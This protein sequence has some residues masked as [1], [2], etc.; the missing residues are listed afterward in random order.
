MGVPALNGYDYRHAEG[1]T[2]PN[3]V[4]WVSTGNGTNTDFEIPNLSKGTQYAVEVRAV[5]DFGESVSSGIT[6]FETNT[7]VTNAPTNLRVVS[8]TTTEINIAFNAPTDDGGAEIEDYSIEVDGTAS[9]TGSTA[10][11]ARISGLTASETV[12]IRV[13]GVNPEGTGAYSDALEATTDAEFAITTAETD[14]REGKAFDI[15]IAATGDVNLTQAK[16]SVTGAT[17]DDFVETDAQNYV[18][19][20]TADAG[21]G[22]IVVEIAEDAVS[23]GNAPVSKTFTRKALPSATITANPPTI[24]HGR[25]TELTI[26]FDEDV[27]GVTDA[28]ASV[29]V[30]S[31]SNFSV[32]S[33]REIT[34]DVT[35][36]DMSGLGTS[37]SPS[38]VTLQRLA[39]PR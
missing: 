12:S 29:D 30:G 18:L 10:T 4:G 37:R 21:A 39:T 32:V 25:T 14:I 1:T 13:A 15:D 27:D 5:S 34:V 6:T 31:L 9:L 35:A 33:A 17:I 36:P 22:D 7:T 28:D 23:P 19:S 38:P 8:A 3:S 16:V 24:R 26:L 11:T 20:V 2:I